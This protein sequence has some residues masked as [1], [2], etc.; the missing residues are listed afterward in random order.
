M[1]E[2]LNG[3]KSDKLNETT[4]KEYIDKMDDYINKAIIYCK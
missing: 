3:E 2:H 4:V 1:K